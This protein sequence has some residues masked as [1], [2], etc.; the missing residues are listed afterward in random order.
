MERTYIKDLKDKIGQEV[1]I[2]GWVD[3]R[4]DH[5]KLIFLDLRDMSGK[6]QMVALPNHAEAHASASTVRSEWVIE[7]SG[8]VNARPPKMVKEGVLNGEL[9]IEMLGVKVLSQAQELPFELG[10]ELNLDTYLDNLPLTLR[11]EKHRAVFKVQA[12]IITAFREFLCTQGFT[13][14]QSPKL[15]GEDAE[16]GVLRSYGPQ[17]LIDRTGIKL[18]RLLPLHQ[19]HRHVQAVGAGNDHG[20]QVDPLCGATQRGEGDHPVHE[21]PGRDRGHFPDLPGAKLFLDGQKPSPEPVGVTDH[22]IDAA[23]LNGVIHPS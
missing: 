6:V 7:V 4:R 22:G 5:G 10:A 14:F 1:A 21:G 3:I 9:E 2:A 13:E 8:I 12:E 11:E 20:L 16:G 23:L 19:P 17:D 18:G 15:I